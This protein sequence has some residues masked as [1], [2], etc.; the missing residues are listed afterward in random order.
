MIYST[1]D[2]PFPGG[3]GD[4][5]PSPPP[6]RTFQ[7]AKVFKK[8]YQKSIHTKIEK[9]LATP[10][11]SDHMYVLFMQSK[12]AGNGFIVIICLFSFFVQDL[13]NEISTRL[14]YESVLK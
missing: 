12:F 14:T 9:I 2:Y 6:T 3:F 10:L 5:Y 7:F 4:F 1:L 11:R 13:M 8:K